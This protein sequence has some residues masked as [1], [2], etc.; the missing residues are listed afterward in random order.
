MN[1]KSFTLAATLALGLTA[2]GA[3]VA[4]AQTA[5]QPVI[6]KVHHFLGPQSVQHTT[7]LGEWC[8][9]IARD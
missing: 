5:Q 4:Q 9:N 2:L 8:K 3:T 6:L 7:M 1:R